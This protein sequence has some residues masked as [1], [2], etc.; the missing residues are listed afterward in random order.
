MVLEAKRNPS[1]GGTY[2][3]GVTA[4][5]VGEQANG[6]FLGHRQ[7]TFYDNSR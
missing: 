3:F 1:R 7:L 2:W 4:Y 5:P 6:I